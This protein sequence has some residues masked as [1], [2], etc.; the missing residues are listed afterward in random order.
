MAIAVGGF[1]AGGS[2]ALHLMA[3]LGQ[4][5]GGM[6]LFIGGVAGAVAMILIFDWALIVLSAGVGAGFIFEA[7]G[8]RVP[9]APIAYLAL[10]AVGVLFQSRLLL[11]SRK[12]GA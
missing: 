1:V 3:Q 7:V 8:W 4:H 11:A 12:D 10:V 5:A 9:F 2:I 6:A